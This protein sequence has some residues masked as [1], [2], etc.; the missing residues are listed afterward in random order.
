VQNKLIHDLKR[1]DNAEI[2]ANIIHVSHLTAYKTENKQQSR[3]IETVITEVEFGEVNPFTDSENF[4]SIYFADFNFLKNVDWKCCKRLRHSPCSIFGLGGAWTLILVAWP[5]FICTNQFDDIALLCTTDFDCARSGVYEMCTL[6]KRCLVGYI[7]GCRSRSRRLGLETALRRARTWGLCLADLFSRACERHTTPSDQT[8]IS[9]ES[10]R[11]RHFGRTSRQQGHVTP[12]KIVTNRSDDFTLLYTAN[13]D[14]ASHGVTD[15]FTIMSTKIF[16][17]GVWPLC[18]NQSIN[19]FFIHNWHTAVD[20]LILLHNE[21]KNRQTT[22]EK[23]TSYNTKEKL[24][25]YTINNS[26]CTTLALRSFY[27]TDVRVVLAAVCRECVVVGGS[28][29]MQ[30]TVVEG[31]R[32]GCQ[33]SFFK[34]C[35]TAGRRTRRA[36]RRS[37]VG[38]MD[39]RNVCNVLGKRR[40]ALS[41]S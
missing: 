10:L 30:R 12:R 41:L 24:P 8:D 14:R 40:L 26:L 38:R 13:F 16:S 2:A 29:A 37:L 33:S 18:D 19:I 17:M 1:H 25:N 32:A 36:V 28:V 21:F 34:S 35:R 22:N 39:S 6:T 3:Y 11:D 4:T 5:H 7:Q 31:V 15:M 20:M 23:Y 27:W 9:A